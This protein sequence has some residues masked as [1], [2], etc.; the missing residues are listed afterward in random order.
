MRL[1]EARRPSTIIVAWVF[2]THPDHPIPCLSGT[3][4]G[5]EAGLALSVAEPFVWYR[6]RST[7]APAIN[8][9]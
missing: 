5:A 8:A 1:S 2:N 9:T 3:S 6:N 4:P 7:V